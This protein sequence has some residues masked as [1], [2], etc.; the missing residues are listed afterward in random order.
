MPLLS[1][2][3]PGIGTKYE[4]ESESGE[5][6]AIIRTASGRMQLYMLTRD[7]PAPCVAELTESE[8]RRLGSI[9]SGAV[10]ESEKERVEIAFSTLSDLR[11]SVHTYTIRKNL[12]GKCIGEL[13]IRTRT[14]VT[15]VAV[16]RN[17]KSIVNPPPATV[18]EEGDTVVAIGETDQL[19]M[20]EALVLE[21]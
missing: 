4:L 14:G 19:K 1:S 8:G 21:V 18:F 16:S 11:I 5:T 10:M 17:E 20:F 2:D 15:V 6:I 13:Q 3:L 7:C 12:A 9:F